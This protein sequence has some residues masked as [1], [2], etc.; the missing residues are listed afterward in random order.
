MGLRAAE[1]EYAFDRGRATA[2]TTCTWRDAR[3]GDVTAGVVLR[4]AEDGGC[5]WAVAAERTRGWSVEAASPCVVVGLAEVF[6]Y[7]TDPAGFALM[8]PLGCFDAP[9]EVGEGG[10]CGDGGA[11]S[12]V[13]EALDHPGR[14]VAVLL[15]EGSGR[16]LKQWGKRSGL[17]AAMIWPGLTYTVIIPSADRAEALRLLPA[18]PVPAR[19]ARIVM[20]PG[21]GLDDVVIAQPSAPVLGKAF[22]DLIGARTAQQPCGLAAEA[23]DLLDQRLGRPR[24]PPISTIPPQAPPAPATETDPGQT[25]RLHRKVTDLT[26]L[27][28]QT[29]RQLSDARTR[30]RAANDRAAAAEHQAALLREQAAAA[31]QAATLQAHLDRVLT[32]H[33]KLLEEVERTAK[34]RDDAVRERGILSARLAALT[35]APDPGIAEAVPATFPALLQLVRE[36]GTLELDGVDEQTAACLDHYPKAALWRRK[37]LDSLRTLS[38]YVLAVRE[39]SRHGTAVGPH[40]ADVLA[41]VRSGAPGVLISANTVALDESDAT[42]ANSRFRAART[43]RVRPQTDPSGWAFFASHVR[44]EAARPPTPRLHFLDDT[45]R[46]GLL[47]IGYLG[48]HLPSSRT[49]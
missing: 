49:N 33:D 14:Q 19:G 9:G 39:A 1:W 17:L 28:E 5:E 31:E 34:E 3:G 18:H 20:P 11:T 35:P 38:S 16:S 2:R 48:P 25:A 42:G 24:Q 32:E 26:A 43:F 29:R 21:H 46:T 6:P 7:C 47:Y 36:W 41:Y 27:L 40:L 8:P 45:A 4:D 12:W 37:S 30:L 22:A 23:V 10:L 15:L 13:V 44:I